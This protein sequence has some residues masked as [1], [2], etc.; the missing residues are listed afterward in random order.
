MGLDVYLYRIDDYAKYKRLTEEYEKKS[1]ENWAKVGDYDKLTDDQKDALRKENT[2]LA[3]SLGLEEDGDYPGE[4][5]MERDSRV[6]PEHLF[7]VG[8]LRSS[9]NE[10]GINRLLR[11]KLNTSLD[12]IFD[13][14]ARYEFQPDWQAARE[15]AIK[16]LED[17]RALTAST[18]GKSYRVSESKVSLFTQPSEMIS[19]AADALKVF[20]SQLESYKDK[21]D[22]WLNFGCKDGEFFLGEPLKV[23]ALIPGASDFLGNKMPTTYVIYEAQDDAWYTQ[24]LEIVIENCEWVLEQPDKELYWLHWSG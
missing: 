4:V 19:S 5:K 10:G 24:A 14:G 3:L 6:Y 8:Y 20:Y 2:A 17:W 22:A 12:E 11:D 9:Y 16:T 18:G 1:D 21:P 7:K 23:C 15:R 13:T